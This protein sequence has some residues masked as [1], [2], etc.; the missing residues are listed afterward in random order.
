[1][2]MKWKFPVIVLLTLVM[3]LAAG[4]AVFGNRSVVDAKGS[5][6]KRF[7]SIQVQRGD[8]LW[9]IAREYMGDEYGT[10]E[11]YIQEVCDTN[12]I[13]DEQIQEGM[14]LVIPYYEMK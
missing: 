13:Y 11:D 12:H 8:S 1:M 5:A 9:S 2:S 4:S 3:F 10:V 14:Y 6:Q 7:T